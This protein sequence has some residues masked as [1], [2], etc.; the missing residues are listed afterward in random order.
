MKNK[1]K[2]RTVIFSLNGKKILSRSVYYKK[3]FSRKYELLTVYNDVLADNSKFSERDF[4][5]YFDDEDSLIIEL[6]SQEIKYG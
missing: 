6:I 4:D 2:L 3:F 1:F 5:I